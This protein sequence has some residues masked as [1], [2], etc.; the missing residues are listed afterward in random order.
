MINC[1]LYAGSNYIHFSLDRENETA[2]YRQ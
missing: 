1:L 2:L